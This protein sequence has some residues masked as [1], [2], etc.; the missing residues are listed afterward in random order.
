MLTG[1]KLNGRYLKRLRFSESEKVTTGA[2]VA[3]RYCTKVHLPFL[4]TKTHLI[5]VQCL[6]CTIFQFQLLL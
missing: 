5:N 4:C 2:N 3:K 1:E 6:I